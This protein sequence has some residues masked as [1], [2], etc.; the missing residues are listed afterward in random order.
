[1]STTEGAPLTGAELLKLAN[2]R[3]TQQFKEVPLSELADWI[4][5]QGLTADVL[6]IAL[7]QDMSSKL[8]DLSDIKDQLRLNNEYLAQILGDHL[9]LN[10]IKD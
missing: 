2:A 3:N 5:A 4:V 6:M 7:L 1:M 8:N 10:D 9:K